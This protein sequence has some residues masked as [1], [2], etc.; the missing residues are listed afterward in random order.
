MWIV[1]IVDDG[2]GR[3]FP[4]CGE[5]TRDEFN[6]DQVWNSGRRGERVER[7]KEP[8]TAPCCVGA[9][10]GAGILQVGCI[11][12][13]PIRSAATLQFHEGEMIWFTR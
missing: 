12:G 3:Q 1:M 6:L 4:D 10:G 2:N 13:C 8:S 9:N 5:W 11:L 7:Q